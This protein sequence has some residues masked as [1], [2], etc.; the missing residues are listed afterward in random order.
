M[1]EYLNSKVSE[2]HSKNPNR[3]K[4]RVEIEYVHRREND[5]FYELPPSMHNIIPNS[6]RQDLN[7]RH[8]VKVRITHDQ[9]TGEVLAKIIKIRVADLNIYMPREQ[10]DCRISVNLEIRFDGDIGD[11]TAQATTDQQSD[12]SKD[13]LSYKHGTYQI[14]LTQVTKIKSHNVNQSTLLNILRVLIC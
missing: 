8:K 6:V 12:R 4:Q 1:N 5:K 7:P 9:K 2:A 3:P 13:R 10:L 11:I 14:D